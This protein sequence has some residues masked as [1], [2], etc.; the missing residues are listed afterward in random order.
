MMLPFFFILLI[1][2][3][4]VNIEV[5]H[6]VNNFDHKSIGNVKMSQM[7]YLCIILLLVNDIFA[8]I[9]NKGWW[10]NMVFYE[11]DPRNFMDSNND[12]IGDLKGEC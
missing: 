8:M 4:S 10:Q 2:F 11:I 1:C 5:I 12:G 7:T 6:Y 9:Q 3:I